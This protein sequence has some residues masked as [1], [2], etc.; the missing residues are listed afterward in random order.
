M[1][2]WAAEEAEVSEEALW[3]VVK[4]KE[5]EDKLGHCIC[6][7][8]GTF[9]NNKAAFGQA[10]KYGQFPE[11]HQR[12]SNVW[13]SCSEQVVGKVRDSP[14]LYAMSF[15]LHVLPRHHPSPGCSRN[16]PVVALIW[17]FS[18]FVL[19]MWKANSSPEF[20]SENRD[21]TL[22]CCG[23]TFLTKDKKEPDQG[24]WVS[25]SFCSAGLRKR[26]IKPLVVTE[27]HMAER[28]HTK[29]KPRGSIE[30][31]SSKQASS[32]DPS[33][34]CA[35]VKRVGSSVC[36]TQ[37]CWGRRSSLDAHCKS[38][39]P[40]PR[41]TRLLIMALKSRREAKSRCV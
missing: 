4:G 16:V 28:N 26:V 11:V 5:L 14:E 31:S 36:H 29:Q 10:A 37:M 1:G 19:H 25:S 17:K 18:I 8:Q 23:V 34:M 6:K 21:E 40:Q 27:S 30:Q 7:S 41:S 22:P 20:I 9:Q 2:W 15:H 24:T 39:M 35:A 12:N 3:V 38:G 32:I 33:E 13:V